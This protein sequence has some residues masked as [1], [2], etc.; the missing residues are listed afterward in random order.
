MILLPDKQKHADSKL[1]AALK[2]DALPVLY[3]L[4]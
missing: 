4:R 2:V 1:P 3:P